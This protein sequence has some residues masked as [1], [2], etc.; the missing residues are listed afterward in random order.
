MIDDSTVIKIG[1]RRLTPSLARPLDRADFYSDTGLLGRADKAR[2]AVS[3][4]T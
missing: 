4:H 1:N 3:S 2:A